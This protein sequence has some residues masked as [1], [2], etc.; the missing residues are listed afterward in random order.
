MAVAGLS[1]ADVDESDVEALD[2]LLLLFFL[3]MIFV[4]L[5]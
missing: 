4:L 1:L 5:F 3:G 2:L